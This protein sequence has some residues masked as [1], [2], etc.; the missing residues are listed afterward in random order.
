MIS[1]AADLPACPFE[2]RTQGNQG[3]DED[4]CRP[5]QRNN[6]RPIVFGRP[7]LTNEVQHLYKVL[8]WEKDTINLPLKSG[9][10][11][12]ALGQLYR[13]GDGSVGKYGCLHVRDLED[14]EGLGTE[15]L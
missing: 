4:V 13:I 12:P 5:Q 2:G 6:H 15:V 1:C 9:V 7:K 11:L 14:L 10:K 3:A 8:L